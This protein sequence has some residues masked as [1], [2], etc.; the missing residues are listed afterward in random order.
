LDAQ[1]LIDILAVRW[2]IEIFF[3]YDKDLLGAETYSHGSKDSSM[4]ELPSIRSAFNWLYEVL[5]VQG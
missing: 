4:P 5:K 2:H 3:E 1:G